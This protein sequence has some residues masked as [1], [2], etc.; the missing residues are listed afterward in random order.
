MLEEE[1]FM[2]NYSKIEIEMNPNIIGDEDETK[3]WLIEKDFKSTKSCWNCEKTGDPHSACKANRVVKDPFHL[4]G[5]F[6]GLAHNKCNLYMRKGHS[7]FVPILLHTFSGND[8]H[9]IFEKLV[10]MAI[11][12]S[13]E[14]KREVNM[15]KTSEN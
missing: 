2:K 9:L 12:K 7:S 1:A 3:C 15:A 14:K 10:N 5:R 4:S 13:I 11:E 6:R 8:N